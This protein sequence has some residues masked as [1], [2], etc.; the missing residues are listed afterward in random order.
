MY[1]IVARSALWGYRFSVVVNGMDNGPIQSTKSLE[2][3]QQGLGR[4]VLVSGTFANIQ[5]AASATTTTTTPAWERSARSSC[6]NFIHCFRVGQFWLYKQRRGM[7]KHNP[8][9]IMWLSLPSACEFRRQ[10]EKF[11]RPFVTEIA[12]RNIKRGQ[13]FGPCRRE[14]RDLVKLGRSWT[15]DCAAPLAII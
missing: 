14:A 10:Q 4:F 2:P 7:Q 12:R 15:Q 8:S 11:D 3:L 1:T 6:S 9:C 5:Q 13:T